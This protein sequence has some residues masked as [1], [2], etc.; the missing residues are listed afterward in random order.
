MFRES[1][2]SSHG[3]L[4]LEHS[5]DERSYL[6]QTTANNTTHNCTVNHILIGYTLALSVCALSNAT[7]I[8]VRKYVQRERE[9]K[10]Q[11]LSAIKQP[12]GSARNAS[13]IFPPFFSCHHCISPYFPRCSPFKIKTGGE[14]RVRPEER[15]FPRQF[16]FFLPPPIF[17]PHLSVARPSSAP[18]YFPLPPALQ[19]S[20]MGQEERRK[21]RGKT[22]VLRHRKSKRTRVGSCSI[23]L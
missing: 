13:F 7:I 16:S 2:G 8:C 14:G 20:T 22:D 23:L 5:S 18:I 19:A 10:Q 1:G 11:I 6:D 17:S 15:D 9:Q 21:E 4:Y 12:P 3:E